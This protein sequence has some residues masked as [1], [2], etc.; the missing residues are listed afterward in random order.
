MRIVTK[1]GSFSM[2]S[3]LS[4]RLLFRFR[5]VLQTR[6]FCGI[7]KTMCRSKKDR[8]FRSI[9]CQKEEIPNAVEESDGSFLLKGLIVTFTSKNIVIEMG[10]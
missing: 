8:R 6:P 5:G 3:I 9:R 2:A 1:V 4:Q 7:P 10:Q